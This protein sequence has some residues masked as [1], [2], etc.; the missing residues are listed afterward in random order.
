MSRNYLTNWGSAVKTDKH[1]VA[2][3]ISKSFWTLCASPAHSTIAG[4]K[5]CKIGTQFSCH[6]W[7]HVFW[8]ITFMT[9]NTMSNTRLKQE[10]LS[11]NSHYL[12]QKAI[13]GSDWLLQS[14]TGSLFFC[15]LGFMEI[16]SVSY[17]YVMI[18]LS[19][20]QLRSL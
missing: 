13:E 8:I 3:V 9:C 10:L 19:A 1:S 7:M 14:F 18:C 2:F 6:L 5:H 11:W 12:I 16:M 4:F 15:F 17:F 20:A